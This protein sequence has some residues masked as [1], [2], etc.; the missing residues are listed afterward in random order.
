MRTEIYS[1]PTKLCSV[2]NT[3][4]RGKVQESNDNPS[5]EP[6]GTDIYN[7]IRSFVSFCFIPKDLKIKICLNKTI[8]L[9]VILYGFGTSTL[10]VKK[11]CRLTVF[12][13]QVLRKIF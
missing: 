13:K 3:R 6:L 9:H 2:R 11:E 10:T 1:V 7:S 4:R 8:I 12:L 5:T